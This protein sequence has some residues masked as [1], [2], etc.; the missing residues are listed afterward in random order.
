MIKKMISQDLGTF[1]FQKTFEIMSFQ[2]N[3]GGF[4]RWASLGDLLQEVAWQHADSAAFG[5]ELFAQGLMWVLSRF[6]IKVHSMPTWGDEVVVKT[7]GRGINRLF[8][9]R[10]F[11]ITDKLGRVL[12]SAMSAWLLLDIK[13]K[14][15]QRPNQVLPT[16]LFEQNA[17][18]WLLPKKVN[19]P[20]HMELG[21]KLMVLPSDLDMNKHVNNVTYLRW[22]EDLCLLNSISFQELD[23]NYLAE[24]GQRDEIQL[25]TAT[26]SDKI[27]FVAGDVNAKQTFA[28][29]LVI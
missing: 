25:L 28:A 16:H 8:A 6:H 29:R 18:D 4:L 23:I 15:P 19:L 11:E 24:A 5:Q 26:E 20:N 27:L 13:N 21:L 22:I 12:V 7:A 14:R 10:E 1:H 2:V 17:E 3:G 9:L